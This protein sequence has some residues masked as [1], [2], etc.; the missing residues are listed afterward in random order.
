MDF[1][2]HQLPSLAAKYPYLQV[3][4][5]RADSELLDEIA[6]PA[7]LCYRGGDLTANLIR[8]HKMCEDVGGTLETM[9]LSEGVIQKQDQDDSDTEPNSSI[10][11]TVIGV[12]DR[13]NWE[14]TELDMDDEEWD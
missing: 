1:N 8:A 7:I 5:S 6:L 10:I 14:E 9:L 13:D 4:A 3:I 11:N 2:L 12:N